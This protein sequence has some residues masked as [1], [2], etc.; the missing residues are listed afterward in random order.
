MTWLRQLSM[1]MIEDNLEI[2]I[3]LYKV[4]YMNKALTSLITVKLEYKKS[5]KLFKEIILYIN[6]IIF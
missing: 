2:V 5:Y 3:I 4:K 1:T 6:S